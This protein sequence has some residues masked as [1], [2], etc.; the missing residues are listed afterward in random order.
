MGHFELIPVFDVEVLEIHSEESNYLRV[1]L[2]HLAQTT[3]QE[4]VVDLFVFLRAEPFPP[5]VHH[6]LVRSFVG[7]QLKLLV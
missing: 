5:R 4:D 7:Q 1:G 3:Y 6:T 2:V